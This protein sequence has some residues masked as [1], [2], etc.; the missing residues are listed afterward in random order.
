MQ[1]QRR[2]DRRHSIYYLRV[3]DKSNDALL[4]HLVDISETGVM[5]V[6]DS[7]IT[8]NQT[9]ELSMK[10]PESING[11]TSIDFKATS[12]WCRNDTNPNFYDAGF[13]LVSPDSNFLETLEHLID[14]YMFKEVH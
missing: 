12:R 6:S 5:I 9:Y 10:L 11:T 1:N 2:Y 8:P 3:F 13:E 7:E 14:A 4:G